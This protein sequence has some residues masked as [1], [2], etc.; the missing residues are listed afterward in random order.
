M[1]RWDMYDQD[2]TL[3]HLT[4]T[5]EEYILPEL[6]KIRLTVSELTDLRRMECHRMG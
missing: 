4:K 6:T 1:D 2:T 5:V 3:K